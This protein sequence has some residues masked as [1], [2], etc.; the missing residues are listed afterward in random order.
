MESVES[1]EIIIPGIFL[2]I[3]T[4]ISNKN[5]VKIRVKRDRAEGK[6][7]TAAQDFLRKQQ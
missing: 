7:R 4:H 1:R 3:P 5:P 6:Y 2:L